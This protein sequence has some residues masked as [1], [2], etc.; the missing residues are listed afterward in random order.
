M[1]TLFVLAAL[2]VCPASFAQTTSTVTAPVL[3]YFLDPARGRVHPLTGIPG[4]GFAGEALDTEAWQLMEFSPAQD[5]A[6]AIGQKSQLVRINFTDGAP[7]IVPVN[8]APSD[9]TQIAISPTGA[10]ALIYS[11]TTRKARIVKGTA[12]TA[13]LDWSSLLGQVTALAI[14]DA[15]DLAFVAALD[16][17]TTLYSAAPGRP[18]QSVYQAGAIGSLTFLRNSHKALIAAGQQIIWIRDNS[19][20]PSPV[21]LADVRNPR[22]IAASESGERAFVVDDA[23]VVSSLPFSGEPPSQISCACSPSQILRLRGRDVFLLTSDLS[24]DPIVLDAG[25]MQLYQMSAVPRHPPVRSGD[26]QQ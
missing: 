14:D 19:G 4:S 11:Q 5:Y 23:G 25:A 15:A 20:V 26:G 6:L 8:G 16:G 3:G 21:I 7:A 13:E 22:A 24:S 2:C 10:A 12:V 18:P 9:I 1:R 17:L